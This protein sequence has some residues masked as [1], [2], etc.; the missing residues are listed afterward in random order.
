M[1]NPSA[2]PDGG[3]AANG[4]PGAPGLL[5]YDTGYMYGSYQGTANNTSFNAP[6]GRHT[7]GSNFLM[8]DT[9]AKFLLPIK[10]SAGI[11]NQM[12]PNLWGDCGFYWS[13]G[14][15]TQAAAPTVGT[16]AASAEHCDNGV[17]TVTFSVH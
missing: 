11:D 5:K 12:W 15:E 1:G 14:P 10:V 6:I 2:D 8:A 13:S 7:G 3:N 16:T 4:G 17:T 9:H